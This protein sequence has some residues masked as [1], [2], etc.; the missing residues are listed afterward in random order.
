MIEFLENLDHQLL[1]QI[2]GAH[3]PV[4]DEVMFWI[5]KKTTWIPLY[6]LAALLLVRKYGIK[7]FIFIAFAILTI[8]IT[9]QVSNHL[10]KDLV[11]RYRPC[12]N[13]DLMGRL[14]LVHNKCGGQYGFV[15]SHAA[16]TAGLATFLIISRIGSWSAQKPGLLAFSVALVAYALLNAYSRVYMG[17]HYPAD[18]LAGALLGVA[19]GWAM[20]RAALFL[21]KFSRPA[22]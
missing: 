14:H 11:A 4:L 15:S 7:S 17:V 16:N 18:V 19:A 22:I 5:S 1:L 9:D 6:I 21:G 12:H 3:T 8:V 2:N 13:L 20:A 10:F